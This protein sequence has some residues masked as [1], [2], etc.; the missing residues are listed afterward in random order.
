M[1]N[2]SATRAGD[3]GQNWGPSQ[4]VNRHCNKRLTIVNNAD[5][6]LHYTWATLVLKFG[7]VVTVE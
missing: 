4:V 3:L 2:Y 6:Y 1:R 5:S 7:S